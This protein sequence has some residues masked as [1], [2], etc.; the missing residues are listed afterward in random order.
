MTVYE[1]ITQ[2]IIEKLEAGTIPWRKPWKGGADGVP[3]N[4][5]SGRP[6]RGINVFLLAMA[7]YSS[8]NWLTFRQ[9]KLL[10]GSV[11]KGEKGY[12][13]VFWKWPEGSR[14]EV[15]SGKSD[16][17]GT[18]HPEPLTYNPQDGAPEEPRGRGPILR[19]YTVFNLSQC[20]G[21]DDPSAEDLDV[22]AFT[23]IAQCEAIV[24]N[25]PTPPR[26]TH[27]QQ[28]AYYQPSTDEINLPMKNSFASP[29]EYYAT[30]FHELT[31]ATGHAS[32]LDR[33]GITDPVLFGSHDYSREELVAE[34]G[35]AFLCGETGIE[36]ATLDSSA[37]YVAGWL[38]R[39][40]GDAKLV[41]T[42]A[43]QAQK[44]VDYVLG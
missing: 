8:P 32:R 21:I 42:A 33:S 5:K 34:M 26:I 27:R 38:K 25:M 11:R 36:N 31:H 40:R 37:A 30:L 9:A 3:R 1:I 20:D 14:S 28:R 13:V 22:I 12:P 16:H 15:E 44:A 19:Y 7:G 29:Q 18:Q 4:L 2:R 24:R 23:P 39:L 41:I 6:Y 43:A 10:G 17:S 35:A